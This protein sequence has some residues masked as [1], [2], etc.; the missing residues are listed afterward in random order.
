MNWLI[1]G[2]LFYIGFPVFMGG[3][4]AFAAFF[5]RDPDSGKTG[6]MEI[7]E[8][9]QEMD[10]DTSGLAAIRRHLDRLLRQGYDR[11]CVVVAF[12]GTD[13]FIQFRKYIHAKG[14]H[15][16]EL[17]FP[18]AEWSREF[19][20]HLSEWC[21]QNGFA[22]D[23]DRNSQ[24]GGLDFLY[25]DTGNDL[26]A[27]MRLVEGIVTDIF[28]LEPD[29][30]F[31]YRIDSISELGEEIDDPTATPLSPEAATQRRNE[32]YFEKTGVFMHDGCVFALAGLLAGTGF[33]GLEYSLAWRTLWLLT[34]VEPGWGKQVLDIFGVALNAR[35]FE[36]VC[37]IL[38]VCGQ[39]LMRSSSARRM[40]TAQ[41]RNRSESKEQAFRQ[42][43]FRRLHLYLPL[44][45]TALALFWLR[46]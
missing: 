1:S 5:H 38:I 14:D 7:A 41:I 10:N 22:Y 27:A 33:I 12:K 34:S 32:L 4:I 6:R 9:W 31:S 30:P 25:V 39:L 21:G 42:Q 24:G 36:I 26:D 44:M 11:G 40:R 17:G 16:L 13:A 46:A 19:F 28:G 35:T 29:S 20:P 23:L 2:W 3:Q 18:D 43:R 15:G 37:L 8:A 45:L